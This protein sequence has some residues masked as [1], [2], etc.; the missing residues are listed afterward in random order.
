MRISPQKYHFNRYNN[1][2]L[3]F[4]IFNVSACKLEEHRRLSV[5]YLSLFGLLWLAAFFQLPRSSLPEAFFRRVYHYFFG[6][7]ANSVRFLRYTICIIIYPREMSERYTLIEIGYDE[8][9][10]TY[11]FKSIRELVQKIEN[12]SMTHLGMQVV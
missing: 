9:L 1:Y 6:S 11:D 2:W 3:A 5:F 12:P 8:D 4:T 7:Q 10:R